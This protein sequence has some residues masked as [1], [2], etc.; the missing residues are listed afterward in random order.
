MIDELT[1][2]IKS[3][4][5]MPQEHEKKNTQLIEE[6]DYAKIEDCFRKSDQKKNKIKKSEQDEIE[7][8]LEENDAKR[9]FMLDIIKKKE[10]NKHAT[11]IEKLRKKAQ[12]EKKEVEEIE[13]R[14]KEHMDKQDKALE[15]WYRR[16]AKSRQQKKVNESMRI[17][18]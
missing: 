11:N 2:N 6:K 13:R 3:K 4:E 14:S 10:Q 15:E 7:M 9:L 16:K 8:R 17:K 18:V 5:E 12:I 1:L